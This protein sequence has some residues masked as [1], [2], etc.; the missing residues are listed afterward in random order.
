MYD[1]QRPLHPQQAKYVYLDAVVPM[2]ILLK[3][4]AAKIKAK[5]THYELMGRAEMIRVAFESLFNLFYR[6]EPVKRK[7]DRLDEPV[8]QHAKQNF[9]GGW[10]GV[11]DSEDEEIRAAPRPSTSQTSPPPQMCG[12]SSGPDDHGVEAD[13]IEADPSPTQGMGT[14]RRIVRARRRATVKNKPPPRL[15][16]PSRFGY[17]VPE[18]PKYNV[19]AFLKF[20]VTPRIDR[21]HNCMESGHSAA[22]CSH[23]KRQCRYCQKVGHTTA[24][25][26]VLHSFCTRCW[27]R[28]HGQEECEN[29]TTYSL[30]AA[31]DRFEALADRGWHTH[32][33]HKQPEWGFWYFSTKHGCF[34]KHPIPYSELLQMDPAEARH[35]IKGLDFASEFRRLYDEDL[36]VFEGEND[37]PFPPL[38]GQVE[39]QIGGGESASSA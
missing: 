36:P 14:V 22:E 32:K 27:V 3:G 11:Y 12:P 31:R 8:E 35:R 6:S 15:T 28:G 23:A 7:A 33:R 16:T 13:D 18:D 20:T 5:P 21:C 19:P 29:N 34:A 1:W 39:V 10:I 4:L 30:E 25:C 26:M 24:A 9:P 38:E 37:F 2:M 17:F